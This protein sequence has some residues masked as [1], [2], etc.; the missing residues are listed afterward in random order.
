MWILYVLTVISSRLS[1]ASI[2]FKKKLEPKTVEEKD[3]VTLEV[4]LTKPAEVKW[5]RNSIVLKPS[6]KIEIKAEGTK[7]ILIV[8]DISFADRGFYCCESPDD[9]TQAKINVESKLNDCKVCNYAGCDLESGRLHYHNGH[10]HPYLPWG[11]GDTAL[12]L[13]TILML[14]IRW[15]RGQS[16]HQLSDVSLTISSQLILLCLLKFLTLVQSFFFFFICLAVSN[17]FPAYPSALL[18]KAH[19]SEHLFIFSQS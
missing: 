15:K 9:K 4:E 6:E 18:Y 1:E 14:E 5:M 11:R 3:T 16:S 12:G 17:L 13:A 7:H 2:S 8:K 19:L 10:C